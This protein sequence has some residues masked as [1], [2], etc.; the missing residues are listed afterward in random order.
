MLHLD[1]LLFAVEVES[2]LGQAARFGNPSIRPY[3]ITSRASFTSRSPYPF[4]LRAFEVREARD[5]DDV[6]KSLVVGLGSCGGDLADPDA[7]R[8]AVLKAGRPARDAWL[9]RGFC[10]RSRQ[11][12]KLHILCAFSTDFAAPLPE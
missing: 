7:D 1:H 6:A 10:T 4:R 3:A 8:L 12:S 11:Y 9:T 2:K 5:D